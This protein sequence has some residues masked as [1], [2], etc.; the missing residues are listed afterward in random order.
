MLLA[1]NRF[2]LL[3]EYLMWSTVVSW[4]DPRESS[5]SQLPKGS[6]APKP[7]S[8][9]EGVHLNLDGLP[10]S[11]WSPVPTCVACSC[12][13]RPDRCDP[14]GLS[15]GLSPQPQEAFCLSEA[16]DPAHPIDS[17]SFDPKPSSLVAEAFSRP[18]IPRASLDPVPCSSCLCRFVWI[19]PLL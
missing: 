4:A 1:F 5:E 8:P 14:D 7:M 9:A 16:P 19:I 15:F 12:E 2:S 6:V 13:T 10:S 18:W 11:S 17:S 3:F